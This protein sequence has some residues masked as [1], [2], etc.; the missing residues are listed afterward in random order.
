[1]K[2]TYLGRRLEHWQGVLLP[3]SSM[4]RL[5]PQTLEGCHLQPSAG[6]A[7][8]TERL[9][10]GLAAQGWHSE[11]LRHDDGRRVLLRAAHYAGCTETLL[12]QLQGNES[13]TLP[14]LLMAASKGQVDCLVAAVAA[15]LR[16]DSPEDNPYSFPLGLLIRHL[17][18][19]VGRVTLHAREDLPELSRVAAVIDIPVQLE[20]SASWLRADSPDGYRV[21]FELDFPGFRIVQARH[22]SPVVEL[23]SARERREHPRTRLQVMHQSAKA[24]SGHSLHAA[25]LFAEAQ[26][27]SL[28]DSVH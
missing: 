24:F 11:Q 7:A 13:A 21:T 2:F 20:R 17:R 23:Y 14:G 16:L 4:G 22:C 5:L 18:N 3:V 1:M 25:V 9:A 8:L 27:L 15:E 19:N 26:A 12:L 6:F 28:C 10:K